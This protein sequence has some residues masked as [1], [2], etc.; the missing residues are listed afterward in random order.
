MKYTKSLLAAAVSMPLAIAAGNATA[1][2]YAHSGIQLEDL[3][4]LVLDSGVPGGV[5]NINFSFDTTNS[6]VLNGDGA[7]E[8]DSCSG[9]PASNNCGPS[10]GIIDALV[11]NAPGSSP[12]QVNNSFTLQGLGSDEYA[13]AD[14]L[15][16]NA[17]L[18]NAQPTDTQQLVETEL[19]T[20]TQASANT[21]LQSTSGLEFSFTIAGGDTMEVDF[22][23]DPTMRAAILGELPGDYTSL[24]SMAVTFL[25]T[26]DDDGS[27]LRWA[28][29]G[30]VDNGC[31]VFDNSGGAGVEALACTETADAEDIGSNS[32][33]ASTNGADS[34]FSSAAG[35]G[36]YGVDIVGLY[37]GDWTLSLRIETS[38]SLSRNVPTPGTLFLFSIGL[39]G[40]ASRGMRRK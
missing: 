1:S 18:V 26:N 3:T 19:Q 25:L 16:T 11:A 28:P 5:P 37:D 4:L 8:N 6:A 10:G 22:T 24:A 9:T 34:T 20:G 32:V 35:F 14:S 38:T 30:T 31:G 33:N 17:Q 36:A 39:M 12:L 27:F 23:A 40:L 29:N 15:V 7:I 21:N 13:Y 2:V